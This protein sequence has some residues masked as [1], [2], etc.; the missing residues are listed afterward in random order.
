MRSRTASSAALTGSIATCAACASQN[1]PRRRRRPEGCRQLGGQQLRQSR[2]RHRQA[3]A[4]DRQARQGPLRRRAQ[5]RPGLDQ[6]DPRRHQR[7]H[8][9]RGRRCRPP[10]APPGRR[11]RQVDDRARQGRVPGHELRRRGDQ[12]GALCLRREEGRAE[13]SAPEGAAS[14]RRRLD[15]PEGCARRGLA[16]G[17]RRPRRGRHHRLAPGTAEPADGRRRG[18]RHLALGL[19]RRDVQPRA[20][21]AR[22]GGQLPGRRHRRDPGDAG[23]IH[24]LVDQ[25]RRGQDD[26]RLPPADHGRL[27]ADRPRGCWRAPAR[28]RHRRCAGHG[29]LVGSGRQGHDRVGLSEP[30]EPAVPLARLAERARPRPARWPDQPV[31][32]TRPLVLEPRQLWLQ[33]PRRR[34]RLAQ[35]HGAGHA[36]RAQ[37]DRAVGDQ[38]GAQGRARLRGREG[39]CAARRRR[40]GRPAGD[41]RRKPADCLQLHGPRRLLRGAGGGLVRRDRQGVRLLDHDRQRRRLGRNGPLPVARRTPGRASG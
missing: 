40:H 14:S 13:H 24:P 5:E 34:P 15:G 8:E 9:G 16:D 29:R 4:A 3:H 41:G 1:A 37:D 31:S 27:R 12:Q 17:A 26:P 10:C 25:G 35:D 11:R 33:P 30:A 22:A 39:V 2:A 6:E 28:A 7:P 19:D 21:P 38:H 32:A 36:G 20:A 18:A 23:R